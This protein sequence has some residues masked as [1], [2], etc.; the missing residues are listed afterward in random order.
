MR[1]EDREAEVGR[2]EAVRSIPHSHFP[3]LFAF[4][5][6]TPLLFLLDFSSENSQIEYSRKS[7]DLIPEFCTQIARSE[8]WGQVTAIDLA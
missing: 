8:V 6:D 4:L 3:I 2:P 1:S 7:N 5:L